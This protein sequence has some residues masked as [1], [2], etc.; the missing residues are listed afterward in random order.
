MSP[1]P[2]ATP[3]RVVV[4]GASGFVGKGLGEM[5]R[6]RGFEPIGLTRDLQRCE[7]KK[8]PYSWRACE[9]FSL[10]SAEDAL[11]GADYAVYLVHSMMPSARLTQ[12]SFRD[13]DLV[14]AD[15][16]ARAA[17]AAGVRHILY[18][19]GLVPDDVELSEHLASRLEV[20]RVLASQ[21]VPVTT[22]RAG[23]VVGAGGSSYEM[24]VRLVRRLPAMICP[25]WTAALTQP[26]ALSDVV[27]IIGRAIGDERLFDQS[28]DVGVPE[29]MSYRDMMERT[30]AVLGVSRPMI[31]VPI[32]SPRLSR[33]W[34]SL[35]T[36]APR[37]LVAP[38]VESLRHSIVARDHRIY[39]LLD[40][41]PTT[42]EECV[43]RAIEVESLERRAERPRA[44]VGGGEEDKTVRSVQ[45]L[46]LP[47]GR[48]AIWAAESY[49]GWLPKAMWPFVVV[50][51]D[52]D[53]SCR[54]RLRG[55][56]EPLLILRF[57]PDRSRADRQLFYVVGGWLA[58]PDGRGR[59]EMRTVP[60][61]GG[62]ICAIHDFEPRLPWFVYLASQSWIHLWVM[63]AFGRHL[64]RQSASL[65]MATAPV[66]PPGGTRAYASLVEICRLSGSDR[67]TAQ[68]H[69]GV[70]GAGGMARPGRPHKT[71]HGLGNGRSR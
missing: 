11:I 19:G 39:E 51:V 32:L 46:P 53:R 13:F 37:E 63:R 61:G 3:P 24:M 5:L 67:R 47:M 6:E 66:S 42:F 38:L 44:F 26:V 36:G 18:L 27:Q 16:F 55:L 68:R 58:N 17:R 41:E 49:M 29:A 23:L 35:I 40:L 9:L 25:K 34:V 69:V 52:D 10:K 56:R 30:A 12:G 60:A 21:T 1:T 64:G 4:A 8:S 22:I 43:L 7:A 14:C 65:V 71:K 70:G 31:G 20:E 15:N 59:L 62:L 45:R 54:F 57:A 2:H 28:F 48:D 33:L 50:D